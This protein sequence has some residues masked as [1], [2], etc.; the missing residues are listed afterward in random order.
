MG[1]QSISGRRHDRLGIIVWLMIMFFMREQ[2]AE[3]WV[4]VATASAIGILIELN[5]IKQAIREGK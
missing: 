1:T 3:L 4:R 5:G 2:G